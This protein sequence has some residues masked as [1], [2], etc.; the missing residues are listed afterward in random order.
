MA[1]AIELNPDTFSIS[2]SCEELFHQELQ[3]AQYG[4]VGLSAYDNL[5]AMVLTTPFVNSGMNQVQKTSSS[6]TCGF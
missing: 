2:R 6:P 5:C 1:H 4:A 3:L